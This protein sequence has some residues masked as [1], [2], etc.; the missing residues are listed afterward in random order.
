MEDKLLTQLSVTAFLDR[1]AG[2]TP[3]PGGGSVAALTG[4]LAAAL[5]RMVTVFTLGRPKFA[6][7]ESR[8]RTISDRLARADQMLRTLIDEDA[9]AYSVL[10]DAFKLKQSDPDRQTRVAQAAALAGGVPLETVALSVKVLA[11][12]EQLRE[13]GNPL[14][15]SDADAATH[16]A[17]A[18][19]HA[20]AANVRAN[21]PL[22]TEDNARETERQ[23][24]AFLSTMAD[25]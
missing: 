2:Q 8:V 3:T 21:L 20:A 16:L 18:A 7:V 11:D 24:N 4:A 22:M 14:L 19:L 9:A 10:D 25:A 23:L 17:R 6:A 5:G 13:L 15:R 1:L 12:L